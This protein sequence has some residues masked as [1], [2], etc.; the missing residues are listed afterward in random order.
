MG[1]MKQQ[2][3]TVSNMKD[4]YYILWVRSP[5]VKQWYAI[6]IVSGTEASKSLKEFT[7]N[8]V[9]KAVGANKLADYQIVRA[10]GMNIYGQ[11]EEVTKQAIQ[12]HPGLKYAKELQF[13]YKEIVNNTA[14]NNKPVDIMN[15]NNISLIPPE[16]E[17]KNILDQAGDAFNS[18]STAVTKVG[19][20]IKGFLGS[21]R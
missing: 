4:V 7:D 19:D 12:M 15:S 6:N 2:M 10:L 14:F 18:T 16:E 1:R 20:N 13:G 5:R 11:K 8:D 3:P 9:A 17:L 21:M